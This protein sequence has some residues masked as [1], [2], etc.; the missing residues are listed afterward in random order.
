LQLQHLDTTSLKLIAHHLGQAPYQRRPELLASIQRS[1]CERLPFSWKT[2]TLAALPGALYGFSAVEYE[3]CLYLYGGRSGS[4]DP[5]EQCNTDLLCYDPAVGCWTVLQVN[6]DIPEPRRWHCA[7]V[8]QHEM[9]VFGGQAWTGQ[10]WHAASSMLAFSFAS[11]TWRT[12]KQNG[13]CPTPMAR[14]CTAVLDDSKLIVL[15]G[16]VAQGSSHMSSLASTSVYD[17]ATSTWAAQV[18]KGLHFDLSLVEAA[19]TFNG[20]TYCLLVDEAADRMVVCMLDAASSTWTV[21][22][23]SGARPPC[24]RRQC[25]AVRVDGT[26]VL[27]GGVS[28]AGDA[29]FVFSDLYT[30][31]FAASRWAQLQVD[32]EEV[33]TARA[34]HCATS[35]NGAA[36]FIGGW[37]QRWPATLDNIIMAKHFLEPHSS[38]GA[39]VPN[40]DLQQSLSKVCKRSLFS[41][42][43]LVAKDGQEFPAHRLV[44]A[45]QSEVFEKMLTAD[46]QEGNCGRVVVPEASAEMLCVL[47]EYLYGGTEQI[48]ADVVVELFQFS[49]QYGLQGLKLEC[50]Q[51]MHECLSVANVTVVAQIAILHGLSDLW[52]HAVSFTSSPKHQAEVF[53]SESYFKLWENDRQAAQMFTQQV[54][55]AAS[56]RFME[57]QTGDSSAAASFKK[58]KV[59]SCAG[60]SS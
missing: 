9:L 49:E 14:L 39:S 26:W 6:R 58:M 19:T 43:T 33:P 13:S 28:T 2:T 15:P 32:D 50:K 34:S 8:H 42:V 55:A 44:L 60:R 47:L 45:S 18:C 12:V 35:L 7:V 3:G 37:H 51:R 56:K 27:S 20:N 38:S 24:S 22:A 21:V 17:L 40:L 53:A 52:E 48:S 5:T 25:S 30:Y 11:K 23:P 29:Q 1:Q 16:A 4:P 59:Q 46:M 41:D 31:D 36:V 54:A 57:L 10:A